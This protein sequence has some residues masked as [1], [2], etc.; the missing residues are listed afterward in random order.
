MP[1]HLQ[2][3]DQAVEWLLGRINYEGAAAG[4][5]SSSDLKLERMAR[6]LALIGN[7]HH[8]LPAVHIAGTKGKGSTAAMT[9]A[10]LTAAG[11]R[12][13][14]FTSPHLNRIEERMAVDGVT[15]SPEEFLQLTRTVA[16]ATAVLDRDSAEWHPTCFE[17][18]TAVAWLYFVA[19]RVEIAVLEVGLGGRLDSTNLC[20]SAVSIVTS[21]SLDHTA[22]LG[23][24]EAEI[25]GEKAGIIR[26]RV[27]VLSGVTAEPPRQVITQKCRDL[28]APLYELD[29]QILV[30]NDDSGSH[31]SRMVEVTTPF[32]I[33]RN[34]RIPLP[35]QHQ[36]RNAA[37]AAGAIDL[38]SEQGW[39]IPE[40]AIETGLASVNWPARI[41]ILSRQP[42]VVVDTAHNAA[43]IEALVCTL[44][45]EFRP[46]R[47]TVVLAVT[48]DKD[49][50]GMLRGLRTWADR[51]VLT[52]YQGNPRGLP[53]ARLKELV[54]EELPDCRALV[55]ET[56]ADAWELAVREL[57]P[58]DLLCVTG[59]I[60]I[61]AELRQAAV[62]F[63]A[64]SPGRSP[65]ESAT[66]A[67]SPA[68]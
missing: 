24:T 55:A 29:R 19:R 25:A 22:I 57:G 7:P 37:L 31:G 38:L 35:G 64:A 12:T 11:Y 3:R 13:A 20:E 44:R 4:S 58:H 63:V 65:V 21:I 6:L 40:A 60:F 43:S 39:H 15:P 50:R 59:S 61:A 8:G 18:M 2:S 49:V 5:F 68:T 16:A 47:C 33:H 26:H 36:R 23:R 30:A 34:L 54:A 9:A 28:Q 10:I 27:P 48:R 1:Q 42:G 32:G 67:A 52:Q 56:P 46:H 66:A 62:D 51:V 45:S 14:L 53:V 41:E 17:L